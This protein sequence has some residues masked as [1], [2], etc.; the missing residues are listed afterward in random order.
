MDKEQPFKRYG[1][2]KNSDFFEEYLLKIY[3]ARDKSGLSKNLQY[4]EAVVVEVDPGTARNYICELLV[5]T[6]YEYVRSFEDAWYRYHLLRIPSQNSNLGH[7]DY[8]IRE[9]L[10]QRQDSVWCMNQLSSNGLKKPYTRY[11]GELVV[12][13]DLSEAVKKLEEVN[14]RFV[15]KLPKKRAQD[16]IHWTM[17]SI[18][19]W[20]QIGYLQERTEVREYEKKN[21][22]I[23]DEEAI[24]LFRKMKELQANLGIL[25]YILPIDHL[26][27]RVYCH[28][29]E[30][31]ILEY[32]T[33]SAYYFWGAYDIDDQNSSTNINRNI[34]G[35]PESRSP[36]KVFTANNTPYYVNHIVKLP[37]PTE[38]FVRNFGR[39]MHHI[40]YAVVDGLY[41]K[42]EDDYQNVDFVVD[43]L[44]KAEKEFL[45]HVIGSCKEGLKQIFSKASAYSY[46]ITEYIQRCDEYEGFFTKEN[47]AA[48]TMAAGEEETVKD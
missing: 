37:S 31:A 33:M 40:A 16:Y 30:H 44:K 14:V 18:F 24:A 25:K 48:L 6:P 2:K 38:D 22:W 45:L 23:F 20:N 32:L 7:P 12:V 42:E 4:I 41:G 36:A 34:H 21:D 15:Q 5:M 28:D 46:L 10:Q 43:Q 3:E 13:K 8:L 47:V 39:R 26:A 17:P 9:E 27:S 35:F 1:D 29:R 11:I 19:T